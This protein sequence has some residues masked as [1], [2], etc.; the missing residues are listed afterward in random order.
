MP[1]TVTEGALV[2]IAV[3]VSVQALVAIGLSIGSWLAMRRLQATITAESAALH[4]RIDEALVHLRSAAASVSRFSTDAGGVA[5]QAGRF[6]DDVSGAIRA[7]ATTVGGPKAL[8]AAGMAGGLRR[9]F[10]VW[11]ARRATR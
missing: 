4:L 8:I 5:S 6:I 7:V 2:A 3:A 10:H 9:L 1:Q 11:Q